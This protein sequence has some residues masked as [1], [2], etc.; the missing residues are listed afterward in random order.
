[1]VNVDRHDAGGVKIDVTAPRLNEEIEDWSVT[2]AVMINE[3]CEKH[4]RALNVM[5][6][7]KSSFWDGTQLRIAGP[8]ERRILYIARGWLNLAGT[9]LWHPHTQNL[10]Q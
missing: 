8:Y 7:E 9:T 6:F 5:Q 4:S 10:K 3:C 2:K 1:M